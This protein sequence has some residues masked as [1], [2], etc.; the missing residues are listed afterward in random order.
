MNSNAKV[1]C[2][3]TQINDWTEYAWL[4][5]KV[6]WCLPFV[7]R[8]T[9]IDYSHMSIFFFCLKLRKQVIFHKKHT[10][11]SPDEAKKFL[12]STSGRGM[13]A[14]NPVKYSL[15]NANFGLCRSCGWPLQISTNFFK[16]VSCS[17]PSGQLILF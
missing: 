15:K 5:K 7:C 11:P 12:A 3:E 6:I 16:S 9:C 17:S 1:H 2:I 14:P 13:L 10:H 4:Q 8:I